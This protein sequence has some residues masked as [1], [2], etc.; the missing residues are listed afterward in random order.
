MPAPLREQKSHAASQGASAPS[1]TGLTLSQLWPSGV[2]VSSVALVTFDA[3]LPLVGLLFGLSASFRAVQD[4][5]CLVLEASCLLSLGTELWVPGS[6]CLG[7]PPLP[8]LPFCEQASLQLLGKEKKG[9]TALLL[10]RGCDFALAAS[11]P[12]RCGFCGVGAGW[13]P[14]LLGPVGSRQLGVDVRGSRLPHFS[15]AVGYFGGVGFTLYFAHPLRY[16]KQSFSAHLFLS[17]RVFLWILVF[18]TFSS[19]TC[20]LEK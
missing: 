15:G 19:L 7:C 10:P 20:T 6:G 14:R 4:V 13:I 3:P 11:C 9:R 2:L 12:G 5:P 1:G 16:W 17:L 18:M 8:G